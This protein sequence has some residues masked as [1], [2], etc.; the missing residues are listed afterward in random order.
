VK[1][2]VEQRMRIGWIAITLVG[3]VLPLGGYASAQNPIESE[4]A[5]INGF[6]RDAESGEFLFGA[7]I[8]EPNNKLGTSSNQ[9][10]F[11][12]LTVPA[13]SVTVQ[14][15]YVGYAMWVSDLYVTDDISLSVELV[16]IWKI[17]DSITVVV[18][19]IQ[20]PSEGSPLNVMHIPITQ[21]QSL[22]AILGEVDPLRSMQLLPGVQAGSEA[23]SGL[24]IRGGSADQTLTLLD[25]G[26]IY[27]IYHLF[28]FYSVFNSDALGHV[29]LL[30]GGIPAR[31]GGTLSSVLDVGMREG[32][33]T[34]HAGSFVL[35]AV[36]SRIVQE[37]PIRKGLG[38]YLV[39]GRRTYI[40][41][42]VRPFMEK[43]VVG[44]RFSDANAKINSQLSKRDKIYGS[45][46]QG[47]DGYSYQNE[48]EWSYKSMLKWSNRIA[49]V[50]WNRLMTNKL[51][52]NITA[53]YS[54]YTYR[55]SEDY[56][57][58]LNGQYAYRYTSRIRE[59]RLKA[60]LEYSHSPRHHIRFGG[61]AATQEF[62]PGAIGINNDYGGDHNWGTGG[63]RLKG[64]GVALYAE[65]MFIVGGRF[66]IN[67]GIRWAAFSVN[68]KLYQVAEPR[69]S[70]RYS[71]LSRWR[72]TGSYGR[73]A[74]FIY[75]LP[76]GGLA[77]PTDLWLPVT[78]QIPMQTGNIFTVGLSRAYLSNGIEF[79]SEGYYKTMTHLVEYKNGA[80]FLNQGASW[81]DKVEL[82]S[83][84]SYG[85]EVLIRKSGT[86][87]NGWIGYT[88][89]WT[90][91]TFPAFNGGKPFPYRYDRRHD[92]A[93]VMNQELA[94][95]LELSA[96]WT[97][98]TGA[99]ISLPTMVYQAWS[100]AISPCAAC[101][102]EHF[103]QRNQYR[104]RNYHRMDLG[105]NVS[106][107]QRGGERTIS[108]GAYNAYN[109]KNPFY[110][111]RDEEQGRNVF[112]QV[113][114]LPIVPYITYRR[115]Y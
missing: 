35:G 68:S 80:Q 21:I 52:S 85:A 4:E 28:G 79:S 109:R 32:N 88:L 92:V 47:R 59:L 8:L 60:D 104:M 74:Q 55:S 18:D 54:H 97:F 66:R 93:V 41:V 42:L 84:N 82:G 96:V 115:T 64:V 101:N 62:T 90:N 78:D 113:S 17:A 94:E 12:S 10:G 102:I 110:L 16:P 100:V 111:Y 65:D 83:G 2:I 108:I 69:V 43:E 14:I 77:L 1:R 53:S 24:H 5:T 22:P 71:V 87:T 20:E 95:G 11:F 44:Y 23:S 27:S 39:A 9:Y 107:P 58:D 33:S 106:R 13:D 3:L 57:S 31:F 45:F 75:L 34:R 114:L 73:M 29:N 19:R 30:K 67:M 76:N 46:Y 99:A 7:H 72:V 98:S 26:R 15:S 48:R 63:T 89:S 86:S 49:T 6:V 91:R 50:R 70:A 51:F 36:A 25:G 56:R 37:G 103:G 38:S 81:E 105:I 61:T 112:K 40:D